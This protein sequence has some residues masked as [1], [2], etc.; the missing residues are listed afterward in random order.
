MRISPALT[1]AAAIA[2]LTSAAVAAPCAIGTTTNSQGRN[3]TADKSSN[4]DRTT[5][6]L[7]GGE[8]AGA[9]KTVGAMNN[10]GAAEQPSPGEKKP[11]E[12]Q[13]IRGPS[14]NDC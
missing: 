7:A 12:G 4:T 3:E 2:I 9:P 11:P 14:S 6:N 10:L 5:K 8:H 1:A 13:V